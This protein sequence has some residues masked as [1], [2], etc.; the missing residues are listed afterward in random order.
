M[1][2]LTP[3][4]L[5]QLQ[6]AAAAQLG[7]TSE[8]ELWFQTTQAI[9]AAGGLTVVNPGIP[10]NLTRPIESLT[11]VA[12][13]RVGV[14]VGPYTAVAPE[15]PQNFLQQI[16]LQGNHRQFGAQTPIL[17]SGATAFAWGQMFQAFRG[18][19]EC[20]IGATAATAAI[21]AP[22][23]RP[24]TSPFT[25]AVANHD[26]TIVW[27][28]PF[29][30]MLGIGQD[31]KKQ[32]TNF[33]LQPTDWGNTLFL[34]LTFGDASSFGDPTGAT[35]AFTGIGGTGNP[36]IQ[37][38]ANYGILGTFQNKLDR[39][40]LVI[41]NEQTL[42]NFTALQTNALLSQLAH[43]ITTNVVVKT[44][45]IQTAALT[46]GVD[47]LATLS[48]LQLEATQL[49][50]DNK[51]IRNNVFNLGLKAFHERMFNTTVPQGYLPL[52]FIDGQS[53]LLAYRGDR[54]PGGSQFNLNSNVIA[55]SANNRQRLIQEYILGGPFPA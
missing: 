29:S 45:T 55:A 10:L 7:R 13:L 33:W 49:V 37:V 19:G 44:G 5:L 1:P 21:A 15:A 24:V 12:Q 23:S 38:F 25:G 35:V 47:T 11:I 52:T 46:A 27:H 2:D 26:M 17:M 42:P 28:V 53:A 4:Q 6:I 32:S 48:D 39:N 18:T 31:I 34:K 41:R 16:Q 36:S 14:T 22:M 40:G 51:P 20:L 50:V 54:L 8:P 9:T 3:E 30:P 43:Q